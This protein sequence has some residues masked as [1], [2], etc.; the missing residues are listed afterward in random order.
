MHCLLNTKETE[1]DFT[2]FGI[3]VLL[4]GCYTCICI[5]G[6][7]KLH[8]SISAS[9]Q[10]FKCSLSNSSSTVLKHFLKQSNTLFWLGPVPEGEIGYFQSLLELT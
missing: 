7:V 1:P 3:Q 10:I 6:L 8:F 9:K 4:H 2:Q 5:H